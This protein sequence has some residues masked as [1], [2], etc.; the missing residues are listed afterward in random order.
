MKIQ[1]RRNYIIIIFS[2][3]FMLA[4][5][6]VS[7]MPS[8]SPTQTPNLPNG[9]YNPSWITRD[10]FE[11][12]PN[13]GAEP[14]YWITSNDTTAGR[15]TVY[16]QS[17]SFGTMSPG[18]CFFGFCQQGSV[19]NYT[20]Q[21]PNGTV[22]T[23]YGADVG[24]YYMEYLGEY[25]NLAK[26]TMIAK[27][28]DD[29]ENA[30]ESCPVV[31]QPVNV[32]NGNMWLRQTDFALP[33][34]GKY[35]E[36]N[37]FY[38]SITQTSGMFGRGWSSDYDESLQI[39][40]GRL[41]RLNM[42]DGQAVYFVRETPAGLFMPHTAGTY[43]YI[44]EN[45]GGSFTLKFKDGTKHQ[46]NQSGFLVS[47]TDLSGNQTTLNY[48]TNNSLT[49]IT[50]PSGRTLSISMNSGLVQ[51]ISDSLGVIA[52]YAYYP[53]TSN[54]QTVTY[55]DG[56]QYKFEYDATT[57]AGKTFLKTVKDANDK[58]LETH[59]YDSQGRAT[60]SEK[61]GGIE[62]YIFDYSTW[63][64]PNPNQSYNPYTLVKHKK[65]ANDQNYIETKY[66]F[67]KTKSRNFVWKA[68][69]NCNCGSGSE[70]MNF[71]Y[72]DRLNLKKKTDAV[73][74]QTTYTYNYQ[75]DILTATDTWGT[76]VYTRNE[77][78]QILTTT[79]RMGGVTTNTYNAA[80][81]LKTTKDSLNNIT[82]IEYPAT[83]NKGLPDS[84]KD[85]RQN[86]AKF[87]WFANGLLQETE[88]ANLK[89][90]AY[91]YDARGRIKTVT[92]ALN[93]VTT[94]NYFDDAQRKVEMIYPNSDKITY[95]YDVRRLLES[96]TDERGKITSYEFDAAYRLSK[97]TDPLAHVKETGYDL[98]S[99]VKWRK[100]A[101]GN[102]T[103]YVYDDFNRLKEIEYPPA[104]TGAI[105]LKETF[106]YDLVGRI[107]EKVDTAGRLT[108]YNY[109]DAL[110]TNT[111]TNA[112]SEITTTKYNA[113]GQKI[114]VKDALNQ[115]YNFTYD[116]LGRQLTQTRDGKTIRYQYDAVGNRTTRIDYTSR[117]TSYNYDNLNR[118]TNIIYLQS[119]NIESPNLPFK[120]ATYNYDD[121]SRL[122][123]AANEAG[124]VNFTYDNRS[125]VKTTTDVFGH[126][127]EYN[128]DANGN[129]TQ[130]KLDGSVHTTYAYDAANRLTTLTDE[131]SQNFTFSYDIANRLISKTLPNSVTTT[132]DYDGMNRLT[133]LKHQSTT[134]MLTD[135]NF[136]YNAAN[137][138][139]QIAELAQTKNFSYDNVDRLTNMTS[140]TL[141]TETYA[142]DSVGNR[143]SS[144]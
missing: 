80:G 138:I 20:N 76:V 58:I 9:T 101:L 103:D 104:A 59:Q 18:S 89:K 24:Y 39:Y 113:R 30:G 130:L 48:N 122:T 5:N 92:D 60:T 115:I 78:G 86:V 116:A 38:N 137:Q 79:D 75:G 109:N 72:D 22:S 40:G 34:T 50:D 4:G 95:K 49:G 117:R 136:T 124:T 33:G 8:P 123:S 112:Q 102:Q 3:I 53:N 52:V 21:L 16:S 32:T 70:V 97:V 65:N 88:D 56:S 134:A 132:Y 135:N 37:R 64:N 69:G 66:F 141:P 81:N 74:R 111:V 120:T 14:Y 63:I 23:G 128:Y 62:K 26:V 7:Q 144:S 90:T 100:D 55:Q 129:R 96:V 44:E 54:L 82:T 106:K 98:M 6:A 105:R 10:D 99:N 131:A 127:I 45:A 2:A 12:F 15:I 47:I 11:V 119:F 94:Y 87:K 83:N 51:S 43:A 110:R 108:V 42:P 71:E 31:G 68:E 41:A 19:L 107:K 125:R 126:T 140:A 61:E 133:R 28:P 13:R 17:Y 77:Y 139:N 27:A 36:I 25:S 143:T 142:F 67:D 114:E 118:L 1:P 29:A 84:I 46:F 57:V 121:L 85:A 73:G 35:I 91:T 93:Q